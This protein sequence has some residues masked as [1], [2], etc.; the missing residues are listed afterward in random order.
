MTGSGRA[1]SALASAVLVLF[2][3]ASYG[4]MAPVTKL[5]YAQGF[6]WQQ[7]TFSQEFFGV[8]VFAV[9]LLVRCLW[10]RAAPQRMSAKQVLKLMGTGMCTCA[11]CILYTFSLSLLPVAAA[12]TMLFQFTWIGTVFQVVATRK[13]PAA[14][15]VFAAA[16]VIVGTVLGSG[17]VGLHD[18]ALD[19]VGLVCGL[20]SAVTCAAF[21]FLSSR[22]E[23]AMEPMQR[24]LVVCLGGVV[25]AL[26][27]CPDYLPSGVLVQGIAPYGL[28]LGLFAMFVPV[29]L[30]GLGTPALPAGLSSV[31]AS[32]ELPC[33]LVLTWLMVGEGLSA[34]QV[35][36]IVLILAGVVVSQLPALRG[37]A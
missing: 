37:K 6:T 19:P 36:G 25:L 3:G 1:R 34:L 30:F 21:M 20:G 12:I 27:V 5:A 7:T 9:A 32:A 22:V 8:V 24:G 18:V 10:K 11:T 17:L 35:V 26:F 16:V 2:G 14:S 29:W 4:M 15:Q 23:T 33:S 13:P 28:L 31:L